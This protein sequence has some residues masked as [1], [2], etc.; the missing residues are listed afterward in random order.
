MTAVS[1][2]VASGYPQSELVAAG[3]NFSP[4]WGGDWKHQPSSP[5]PRKATVAYP[6]TPLR[7]HEAAENYALFA[8]G[9]RP[10]GGGASPK[11]ASRT[12]PCQGSNPGTDASVRVGSLREIP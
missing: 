1:F 8:R 4:P 3:A 5:A 7:E 6:V 10:A 11:P 12:E 2:V 9:F